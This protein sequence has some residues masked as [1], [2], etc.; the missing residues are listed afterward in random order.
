M[1]PEGESVSARIVGGAIEIP[2]QAIEVDEG[3]GSL[4]FVQGGHLAAR[5]VI[6]GRW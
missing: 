2:I 3:C 6:G 5:S 1:R 4:D